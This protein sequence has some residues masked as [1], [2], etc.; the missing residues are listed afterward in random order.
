MPIHQ[1]RSAQSFLRNVREIQANFL[2]DRSE[3]M[4]IRYLWAVKSFAPMLR[5]YHIPR[6]I[7]YWNNVLS[8]IIARTSMG[9]VNG[10][11]LVSYFLENKIGR[12][13]RKT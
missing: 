7:K 5:H 2:D 9:A 12:F 6:L 1:T 3:F 4:S 8:D 10:A 13:C 11:I